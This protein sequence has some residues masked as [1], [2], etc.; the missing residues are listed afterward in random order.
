MPHFRH[1][2]LF[3]V[4]VCPDVTLK[5]LRGQLGSLLGAERNMQKFSFLKCVGRS[6]ALVG[7][8]I[9]RDCF[10]FFSLYS[11]YSDSRRQQRHNGLMNSFTIQAEWKCEWKE[12]NTPSFS[13]MPLFLLQVKNKQESSL[14]VKTFAPPY[15]GELGRFFN[16]IF[17]CLNIVFEI[18]LW[19]NSLKC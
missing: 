16:T 18:R 6:L 12:E 15:V 9:H 3:Y 1:I 2:N 11:R 8:L 4:R 19:C 14:K 5:T 7:V 17:H 10:F 13:A